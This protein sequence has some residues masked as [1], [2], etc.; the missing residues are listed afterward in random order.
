[1]ITSALAIAND[2]VD[3]PNE[4]FQLR[5]TPSGAASAVPVQGIWIY[6]DDPGPYGLRATLDASG[7][8]ATS[9]DAPAAPTPSTTAPPIRKADIGRFRVGGRTTYPTTSLT[10]TPGT[11]RP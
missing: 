8:D 4:W 6:D 11:A 5:V 1:V 10:W 3:E 9:G 7:A 2:A